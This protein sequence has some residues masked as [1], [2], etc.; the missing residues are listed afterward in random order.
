[1]SNVTSAFA[2]SAVQLLIALAVLGGVTAAA[3]TGHFSEVEFTAIVGALVGLVG[4]VT[5]QTLNSPQPNSDL[6]PHAVF[7]LAV[8][9]AI[10]TLLFH[11][12]LSS[13]VATTLIAPILGGG[14]AVAASNSTTNAIGSLTDPLPTAPQAVPE[15]TN[16]TLTPGQVTQVIDAIRAEA[17]PDPTA[18]P[19]P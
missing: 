3:Y 2:K 9:G 12:V 17:I 19:L 15:A 16:I 7:T 14:I 5:V 10:F 4:V 6:L 18:S 11:D 8:L 1:M 13:L